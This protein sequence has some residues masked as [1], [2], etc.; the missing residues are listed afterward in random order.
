MLERGKQRFL[1]FGMLVKNDQIRC[2]FRH[3]PSFRLLRKP[4]T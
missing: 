1:P 2:G 4:A 3:E